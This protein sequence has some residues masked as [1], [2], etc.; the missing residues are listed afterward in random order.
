MAKELFWATRGNGAFLR[1]Q[2]GITHPISASST[3][4]IEHAVISMDP[5]YGRDSSGVRKF[6]DIQSEILLRGVRNIRVLGSTGLNM[7][8]VAC[9]RLDAAFEE[10][11]WKSN[12]GPKIWDFA[13][14]MLLIEEAGGK[15]HDISSE[16]A[17]TN[18]IVDLN[19][20][21]DLMGRS[22]FC[23][24]TSELACKVLDAISHGRSKWEDSMINS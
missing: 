13:A 12:R 7:A 1:G 6:C 5:G 10:G 15:T 24:S 20:P 9:G 21:I 19:S 2:D 8:Y 11:S 4:T 14:G 17:N 23:A 22:F 3:K 16:G 18:P